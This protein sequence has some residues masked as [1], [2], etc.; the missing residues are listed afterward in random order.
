MSE[1]QR[2]DECKK[3]HFLELSSSTF[4]SSQAACLLDEYPE[5]Y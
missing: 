5:A 4:K 1:M 2:G 3:S